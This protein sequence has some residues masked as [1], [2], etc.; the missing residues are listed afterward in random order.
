MNPTFPDDQQDMRVMQ[1]LLEHLGE[2][3]LPEARQAGL[4][5][6]LHARIAQ[7]LA[8]RQAQKPSQATLIKHDDGEWENFLPGIRIKYLR[9]SETSQSYLL[10]LSAGSM[11]PPHRH[12]MI[13][14]CVVLEGCLRLRH[15][16]DVL[17]IEK[18]SFHLAPAGED[19]PS[20]CAESDALIYLRGAVTDAK[21]INW[22]NKGTLAALAPASIKHWF[23]LST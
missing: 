19:H 3:A 14:E 22:W 17:R 5:Q 6:R 16:A 1:K 11:L 21:D 9:R 23:H 15:G 13:E 12:H 7:D 2:E 20:I 8:A 18:G 10:Q 4:Q